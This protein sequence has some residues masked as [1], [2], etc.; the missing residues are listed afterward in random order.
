MAWSLFDEKGRELKPIIFS[1][2]KTQEDIANNVVS[3]IKKGTK[4]IFIHGVCGS[5]K[6]AIAL[7]IAKELGRASI[8]VPIKNLQRQYENDYMRK[9]YVLKQNGEKLKISVI[10]GRRNH[11]CPYLEDNQKDIMMA[12]IKEKNAN[13]SD[14]FSGTRLQNKTS[15]DKSCDSLI[16][17]CKIE[18]KNKNISILKKYYT[19]N[20]EK[21]GNANSELDL[22]TMKR[23]AIA[24]A[25]Q[26]WNPI[27]PAEMNLKN[28]WKKKSYKS[29][30]GEHTIYLRKEGCP[31]YTQFQAY[32]DSDVIIF[33]GDQ[34]ILETALGRKPSTDVEII[35]ECDEFLDNFALEGTI[36]LTRLRTELSNCICFEDSEKKLVESLSDDAADIIRESAK[37]LGEKDNVTPLKETKVAEIIKGLC[38]SDL[39]EIMSDESYLEHCIEVSRKFYDVIDDAYINFYRDDNKKEIYAKLVTINLDKLLTSLVDKNKAFVFMSGTLH[40]E[41]VLKEIFGLKE[42][43]IIDAETFN[44][45]TIKKLRSGLEMDFKFDNFGKKLVSREQY[46]KALDKC[47][48]IAK[49]PIVVQVSAFQDLPNESE[50]EKYGL[51]NLITTQELMEQQTKDREGKLVTDFKAGKNSILFTTRCSRGI[52][53]PFETCNSVVITK[54]P[55]PNVQSLFWKILK[56]NKPDIFWDFY[57]DK[58]HRELL[59]RVYRSVRAPTDSVFLLSPDI[60]VLNSR[61]V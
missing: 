44:Q 30:G 10:T 41:R 34:Y 22:K 25:C 52:D 40:S 59:Q 27:L 56:K 61:V 53:F 3:E 12:R 14:I 37:Y 23:F 38:K 50:K 2:G 33:N 42:F 54:F 48:Q 5:G 35:D 47:I 19:E 45:G 11:I 20:P 21:G 6:S 29:V 49:I 1:N 17:P 24:P 16:I 18:I 60:R 4:I 51:K 7:N 46:L 36:N 39:A 13:L 15:T 28:N 32:A 55:Y 26:F 31:Y 8:V 57:R 9:K 58:A 43:K